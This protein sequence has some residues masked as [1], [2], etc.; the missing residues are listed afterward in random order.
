MSFSNMDLRERALRLRKEA[1]GIRDVAASLSFEEDSNL[2]LQHA[3]ALDAEAADLEARVSA[4]HSE[5]V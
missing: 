5:Q 4:L 2:F 1:R 3:A